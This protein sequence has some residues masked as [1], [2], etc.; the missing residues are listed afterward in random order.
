MKIKK[1]NFKEPRI[2]I[3]GGGI[4]LSGQLSYPKLRGK[5]SLIN[6]YKSLK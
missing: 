6:R 1:S 3:F 2:K 5:I 4:K